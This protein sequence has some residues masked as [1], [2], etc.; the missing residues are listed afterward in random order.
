MLLREKRRDLG[1]N[2]EQAAA[3][4]G[5]ARGTLQRLEAGTGF[6]HPSTARK[7]A[8][9]YGLVASDVWPLT[10]REEVASNA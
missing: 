9:F 3:G 7:V 5:V 6:P 10:P 8:T 2:L 1:L 4:C